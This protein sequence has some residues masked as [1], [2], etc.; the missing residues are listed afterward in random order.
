MEIEDKI[1]KN[2]PLSAMTTFKIGGPAKFFVVVESKAEL[3]AAINW[4]KDHNEKIYI[5]GGGS[6]VLINDAGV[7]GLVI[8]ISNREI[9]VEG[10]SISCGAGAMLGAVVMTSIDHALSGMEW[11]SGIPGT[12]GGAVRGNAG[13]YGGDTSQNV[14]RVEVYDLDKHEFKFLDN[15]ACEFAYR[16]SI[17]KEQP[18]LLIWQVEFSFTPGDKDVMREK[19]RDLVKN[20]ACGQPIFPSAGCTFKNL[21]AKDVE[22]ANHEL[23]QSAVNDN[24]IKGGKIGCGRFIDQLG[25]KGKTIGGAMVSQEHGNFIV[26]T[27]NATAADVA[28]LISYVKQQVRDE[29]HIQLEEEV[30]Y[31]GFE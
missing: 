27:G 15:Q 7:N 22:A 26:N 24:L 6:N 8:K 5:L 4:A 29:H 30:Q 20:R 13:A 1:Q 11:A 25:I 10:Q 23:Y 12:I 3:K 28:Q 19:M 21:F 9:Q 17:F 2:V 16:H 31:F 18:S 14:S